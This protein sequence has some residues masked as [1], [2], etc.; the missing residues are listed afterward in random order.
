M[1]Y[2]ITLRLTN[3]TAELQAIKEALA[4]YCEGYGDLSLITIT[5]QQAPQESLWAPKKGNDYDS[6]R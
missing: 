2:T 5:A 6:K 1:T 3:P 4:Y